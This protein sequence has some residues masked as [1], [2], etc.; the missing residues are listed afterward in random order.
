MT[1]QTNRASS[2]VRFAPSPTGQIHI[3]NIR[4]AI[5]NWLF[6][7]N[8]HGA[9]LVRVEDTDLERSTQD[10]IE[11]LFECM[12]WLGLDY[13]GDL[14]YQTKH[15][16]EHIA[17]A[18]KLIAE[19][20]AYK[21][22]P[23]NP[24]DALP[25][26]FCIPWDTDNNPAVTVTGN[27]TLDVHPDEPV[28]I[29]SKG[30]NYA[31]VSKKGKPIPCAASLAGFH[32]LKILNATGEC[33]FDIENEIDGILN[34]SRQFELIDCAKFTFQRRE[35]SFDDIIKGKLS[36]P[37]DT[38][39]DFVIVRGNGSPIFHLANVC[40]DALQKITCIVRGD[41]H[42]ENS[43]RHVFLFQALGYDI[44]KYAHLPM[45]VNDAGKPY[46]K[47]DGDAFVGD[48]RKN[49]FLPEALF[50]Y[51]ALLGW[52]PGDDRE[53]MSQ[54]ELAEAFSLERVVSSPA[55]F[56]FAKLANLNG[57]YIAKLETAKFAEK[58]ADF[59]KE[60]ERVDVLTWIENDSENFA[61]VTELMQVR[62][63]LLADVDSWKTFFAE[64]IEYDAK[65]FRKT[66]KPEFIPILSD[67]KIK[68]SELATFA[69]QEIEKAVRDFE[70]TVGMDEG[71]LNRPLRVAV[72]GSGSGA[73]LMKTLEIIGKH[74]VLA[75]L[76]G[77]PSLSFD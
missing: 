30:V 18:E 39:K 29:S 1:S 41:D 24:D 28:K 43:Y 60:T 52:S 17:A 25:V 63:K 44:P 46:S 75:R 12:K 6:A 45:I 11:K 32:E 38:I 35:V 36:K 59:A 70:K 37:L 13:D 31:Q 58:I 55:H 19:K 48:F 51:L 74:K 66:V 64:N 50:N 34:G 8:Q 4:T 7:R 3:G 71:K 26:L 57:Q 61:K 49:G 65:A 27:I 40:D 20:K 5:F 47:R 69:E 76:D 2:C 42:V 77:I 33:I 15:A 54:T 23:K 21:P 22:A 9:F 10:A 62:T 56:D 53:K 68:L 16:D 67:L 73:D 72:T 14:F